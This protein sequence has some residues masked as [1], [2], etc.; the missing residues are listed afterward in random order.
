MK[1]IGGAKY[2]TT[3]EAMKLAEV[4][5]MTL[6]RWVKAGKVQAFIDPMSHDYLFPESVAEGLRPINRFRLVNPTTN[7]EEVKG[8]TPSA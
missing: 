5:R 3:T 4:T 8:P 1:E 6:L 2:Y 7:T